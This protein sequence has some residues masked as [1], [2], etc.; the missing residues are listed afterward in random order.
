MQLSLQEKRDYLDMV[1]SKNERPYNPKKVGTDFMP[2]PLSG[3]SYDQAA[4]SALDKKFRYKP[5]TW[6]TRPRNDEDFRNLSLESRIGYMATL[7]S[8]FGREYNVAAIPPEFFPPLGGFKEYHEAVLNAMDKYFKENPEDSRQSEA[9]A[10]SFSGNTKEER[11]EEWKPQNERDFQEFSLNER[12]AFLSEIAAKYGR[13][14]STDRLP[15][16]FIP[17][18]GRSKDYESA[19]LSAMDYYFRHLRNN[20]GASA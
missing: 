5:T 9:F 19:V 4:L 6:D 14:Y 3:Q 17:Y 12:K 20:Q 13:S 8:E 16:A 2:R 18:L 15:E 11:N 7:A 10:N 1:A